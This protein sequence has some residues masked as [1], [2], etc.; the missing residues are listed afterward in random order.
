MK[1]IIFSSLSEFS[2]DGLVL[3]YQKVMIL[4][5]LTRWMETVLV[6]KCFMR[7]SNF[8]HKLNSLLCYLIHCRLRFSQSFSD[9]CTFEQPK[10]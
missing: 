10:H 8:A 5:S 4:F 7:Y 6:R 2:I 3:V 1:M 9:H